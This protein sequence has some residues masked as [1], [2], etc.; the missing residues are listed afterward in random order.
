MD[1]LFRAMTG[2]NK[3]PP[4][5]WIIT[6]FQLIKG[7]L[8]LLVGAGVLRMR[9]S[10]LPDFVLQILH[11]A[12]LNVES[13]V[14]VNLME[15]L[16]LIT[17]KGYEW[18]ATG[19]ILSG[20]LH[21][22]EGFGLLLRKAWGAW[23]A[24]IQCL[25]FIPIEFYELHRKFSYGMISVIAINFIVFIYLFANRHRLFKHHKPEGANSPPKKK[26]PPKK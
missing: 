14:V 23:L 19:S 20:S 13:R 26:V 17:P 8:L 4:M 10:N 18:I 5:L 7:T 24:I 15:K 25:L 12:H 3:R 21:L 1:Y 22:L 9:H 6:F 16:R 2:S 11:W